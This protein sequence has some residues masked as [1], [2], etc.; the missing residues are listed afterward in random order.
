MDFLWTIPTE[1]L[2]LPEDEIHV[3]RASQYCPP[4][5]FQEFELTLAEDERSRAARFCLQKDREQYVVTRGILRALLGMYVGE[6]PSRLRFAYTPYGKPSLSHECQNLGICFNV[7]HSGGLAILAFT[8]NREVGVDIEQIRSDFASQ[9][10]AERF[11]SA[12][13][14][15]MLRSLGNEVRDVAF[16]NCWT[17]K[18]AYIKA[19]GE[20]L[21]MPLHQFDVSLAPGEPAALLCTRPDRREA[22][23]WNLRE[24]IPGPGFVAAIAVRS[25]GALLKCWQW[26]R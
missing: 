2:T 13:E 12:R 14:A 7:S 26:A 11:F 20:G 18:E 16:F 5:Q 1:L 10:I 9:E 19:V 4:S 17:R 3:W 8:R 15:R 21:S 23:R 24:L 25:G 6:N 22:L